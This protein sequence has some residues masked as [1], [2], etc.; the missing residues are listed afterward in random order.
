[1]KYRTLGRTGLN[2]SEIGLGTW[3]FNSSVYG[4]VDKVDALITI[5]TAKDQGIFF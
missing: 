5:E 2:V 1:M 3:A 4:K